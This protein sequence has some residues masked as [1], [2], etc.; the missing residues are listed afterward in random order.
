MA[1]VELGYEA[2]GFTLIP[3]EWLPAPF[4]TQYKVSPIHTSPPHFL[5]FHQ[6]ICAP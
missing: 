2:L 3:L 6:N 5:W 1:G 4:A